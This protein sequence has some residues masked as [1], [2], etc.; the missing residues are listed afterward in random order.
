MYFD[1]KVQKNRKMNLS[2]P[3]NGVEP[4]PDA[5]TGP[6]P[7]DMQLMRARG[8]DARLLSIPLEQMLSST[9]F[10]E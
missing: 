1:I 3:A 9:N 7:A 10:K 2:D 8:D 4:V 6:I 5:S